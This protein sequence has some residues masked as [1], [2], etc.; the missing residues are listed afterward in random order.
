MRIK[1]HPI[2]LL[3]FIIFIFYSCGKEKKEDKEILKETTKEELVKEKWVSLFN[4]KNLDNW[5]VKIKGHPLNDNY[6]NT[7]RAVDGVL[8]VNYDEYDTF[9]NSFGHIYYNKEFS[10]YRLRLEYRFTGEQLKDGAGWAQRNSGAMLHCQS[11]ETIGLDQD[12]PISIETQFLG[13][14]GNGDTRSTVNVCTPGT[15]IMMAGEVLT[16]HCINS[17]S[18]TYDGDQWVKVDILVRNDSII[19]HMIDGESVLTYYKP[20]IGG[21]S[22]SGVDKEKW[23]LKDGTPLKSGYISLQSESHPVEFRNIEILEYN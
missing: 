19:K 16:Q 23:N 3:F 4:G 13:G 1:A 20:Q 5:K 6:K 11:P 9:D 18:Q 10:D 12:F 21:G 7:F 15:N 2:L 17:S 14:L 22:V 8:Q